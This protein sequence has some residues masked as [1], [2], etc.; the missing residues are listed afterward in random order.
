MRYRRIDANI[1]V[2]ESTAFRKQKVQYI[3]F[4]KKKMMKEP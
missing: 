2:I 4:G 1:L 3:V